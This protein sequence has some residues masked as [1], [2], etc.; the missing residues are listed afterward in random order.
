MKNLLNMMRNIFDLQSHNIRM[1][2][3]GVQEVC[4]IKICLKKTDWEL[5][6]IFI[7]F[8]SN[9]GLSIA[10]FVYKSVICTNVE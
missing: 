8:W 3:R 2:E 4:V 6:S 9:R 7:F 5:W 1:S 10:I